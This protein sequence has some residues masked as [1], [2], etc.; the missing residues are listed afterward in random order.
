MKKK[1]PVKSEGK[2]ARIFAYVRVST[3]KQDLDNQ[4]LEINQ[5]CDREGLKVNGWI[6][7]EI[8]SRRSKEDRGIVG[9]LDGLKSGDTLIVSELS[10]LGRSLKEILEIVNELIKKHVRFIAI[11]QNM[12]I[13]GRNDMG[14]KVMIAMFGL[15][16]EIERD[17]ISERTKNGLARAR[18]QG[19][20]LGNPRFDLDNRRNKEEAQAYAESMRPVLEGFMSQGMSQRQMVSELNR[21]G[22]RAR[23]GGRW[24]LVQLQHVINRLQPQERNTG[25]SVRKQRVRRE[26]G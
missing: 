22:V 17:L 9:L 15:L 3:V 23:R 24:S 16:A 7:V 25:H 20:R 11:K 4:V 6:K 12:I 5:Y 14:T 1:T 21:L 8:S 26:R 10:R 18:A 19:K 13:N 2:Q